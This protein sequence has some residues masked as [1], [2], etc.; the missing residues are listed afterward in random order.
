MYDI[1]ACSVCMSGMYL[2]YMFMCVM[3]VMLFMRVCMY[4]RDVCNVY[5]ECFGYACYVFVCM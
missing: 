2:L 4:V 5:N 1:Y 3:Y